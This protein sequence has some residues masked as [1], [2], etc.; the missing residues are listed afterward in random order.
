MRKR[1]VAAVLTAALL[2][3]KHR[4]GLCCGNN[5]NGHGEYTEQ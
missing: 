1:L 4:G 2:M 3:T 5:R